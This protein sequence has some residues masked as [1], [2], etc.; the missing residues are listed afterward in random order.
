[1]VG[2]PLGGFLMD[3]ISVF[4]DIL[5]LCMEIMEMEFQLYGYTLSLW[6]IGVW[7]LMAAV[8]LHFVMSALFGD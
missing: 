4:G 8:L 7:S 2:S 1:M 5:N 6:Q 3:D